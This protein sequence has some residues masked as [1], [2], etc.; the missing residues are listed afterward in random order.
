MPAQSAEH[1]AVTAKRWRTVRMLD[2]DR[3]LVVNGK[4]EGRVATATQE[5]VG[6]WSASSTTGCTP[7]P[8][9]SL[10]A[11]PARSCSCRPT[12]RIRS[13]RFS[14][15]DSSINSTTGSR[16]V[17]SRPGTGNDYDGSTL[18]RALSGDSA[19]LVLASPGDDLVRNPPLCSSHRA[20]RRRGPDRRRIRHRRRRGRGRRDAGGS[21]GRSRASEDRL[22][23]SRSGQTHLPQ[24]PRQARAAFRRTWWSTGRARCGGEPP[25]DGCGRRAEH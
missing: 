2:R 23:R 19:A 13:S 6:R 15:T 7:A 21:S 16:S 25:D 14:S 10:R 8:A 9:I 3:L 4:A 24:A 18:R 20:D 12:P 1:R 11:I 5:R 17:C 22:R